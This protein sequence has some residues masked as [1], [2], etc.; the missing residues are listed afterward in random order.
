MTNLLY[1]NDKFSIVHNKRSKI[2]PSV[3]M[4]FATPVRKSFVV[5]IKIQQDPTV[6][7]NF[8]SYLYE[9]QHVLGD[10]PPIIRSLKPHQQPLVLHTWRVVGRVV[11]GRCQVEY[12][13]VHCTFSYSAWELPAT[14]QHCTFSY[15]TWQRPIEGRVLYLRL[16]WFWAWTIVSCS[17]KKHSFR[18]L[19]V[20]PPL[21]GK[22]WVD[23][24]CTFDCRWKSYIQSL[25]SLK[26]TEEIESSFVLVTPV[27][28]F[29]PV[30]HL[31]T[32]TV[33]S[34]MLCVAEWYLLFAVS[35]HL[36]TKPLTVTAISFGGSHSD[37]KERQVRNNVITTKNKNLE[38][39]NGQF[40][41]ES[42][43]FRCPNMYWIF[44][45]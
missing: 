33:N 16:L 23:G 18:E 2:P 39:L 44:V 7:Q 40:L 9:A 12:E 42:R 15:S 14:T 38:H 29:L 24:M 43:Q 17:K 35:P 31:R 36:D 32:E 20:F 6:Y 3:S 41:I 22:V 26:G 21:G 13:K 19:D 1:R 5:H 10:I 34:V 27:S 28:W 8:I 30:L 37:R 25:L 11:A 45:H 4:H